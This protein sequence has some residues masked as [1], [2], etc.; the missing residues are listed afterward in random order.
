MRTQILMAGA[1]ALTLMAVPAAA[2]VLGGQ[3]GGQVTGGVGVQTQ[4]P[5]ANTVRDTLGGIRDTGQEAVSGV[6]QTTGDAVRG[7]RGAID[8][9][10]PRVQGDVDASA[11][12]NVHGQDASASADLQAGLMLHTRTGEMVGEVVDVTRN[13]AGQV[14]RIGVRTADGTVRSLPPAAVTVEGDVAVTQ[15]SGVQIRDLPED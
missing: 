13:A 5:G 14:T 8:Q 3:V 2:Q 10:D 1:A 9:A 15:Y 7:A 11:D 12:A 6:R 4:T